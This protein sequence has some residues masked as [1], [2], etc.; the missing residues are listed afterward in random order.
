RQAD[1]RRGAR[2]PRDRERLL[3]LL[4]V[5]GRRRVQLPAVPVALGD[6]VGGP[7]L[8]VVLI[9]HANRA[10][11]VV[12]QI[13]IGRRV[14]AAG[15]LVAREVRALEVGV[16]VAAGQFGRQ[17]AAAFAFDPHLGTSASRGGAA[18]V[19]VQ[20]GRGRRDD[21]LGGAAA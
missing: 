5:F 3:A 9:L 2:G 19:H 6:F 4:V 21:F 13:L 7:E 17:V 10:A 1:R 16:L 18:A 14:V 15:G 20:R 12:D 11:D 8:F